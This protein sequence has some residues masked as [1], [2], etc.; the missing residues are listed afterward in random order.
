MRVTEAFHAMS[1]NNLKIKFF[2]NILPY[3]YYITL[4]PEQRE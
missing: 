2:M 4:D 1:A 3:W